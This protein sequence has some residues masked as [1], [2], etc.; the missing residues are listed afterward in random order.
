MSLAYKT[1]IGYNLDVA[2]IHKDQP[3]PNFGFPSLFSLFLFVLALA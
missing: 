2:R 3:K 1:F